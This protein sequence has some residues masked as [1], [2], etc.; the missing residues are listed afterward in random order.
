MAEPALPASAWWPWVTGLIAAFFAAIGVNWGLIFFAACG[1]FFGGGLG[2]KT[3][4]WRAIAG[5]PLS[6]VLAAKAGIVWA[7]WHGPVGAVP[8]EDVAQAAAALAGLVFHPTV[9]AVVRMVPAFMER[10][11]DAL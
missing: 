2:P 8:V 5:F 3:G 6:V 7:T 10:K 11:G 9:A 4:R 1:A